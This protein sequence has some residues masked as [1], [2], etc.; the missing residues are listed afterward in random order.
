MLSNKNKTNKKAV[1]QAPANHFEIR[2]KEFFE[3]VNLIDAVDALHHSSQNLMFSKEWKPITLSPNDVH[4][5]CS[6][7]RMVKF[8][9]QLHLLSHGK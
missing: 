9:V 6:Q 1:E 7:N 2:T 5:I 8:L 4:S 3:E